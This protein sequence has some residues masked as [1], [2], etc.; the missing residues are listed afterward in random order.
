MVVSKSNSDRQDED[1][2]LRAGDITPPYDNEEDLKQG[3]QKD[4]ADNKKDSSAQKKRHL[5]TSIPQ[6]SNNSL[7]PS[8]DSEGR[9]H[10]N[11]H[12]KGAIPKFDLAEDIMAEQ[13]KISA[14]RRRAPN[15]KFQ[16]QSYQ[17]QVQYTG[18]LSSL[19]A[20]VLSEQEQ[21]IAEIVARDIYKLCG[22]QIEDTER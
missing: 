16:V 21:I 12:Q 8:E 20:P 11:E 10:G 5:E 19:P 1:D 9:R 4:K 6:N 2:T 13:R 15:K 14:A 17:E 3:H 18:F 7:K 22:R